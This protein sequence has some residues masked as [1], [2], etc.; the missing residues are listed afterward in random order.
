MFYVCEFTPKNPWLVKVFFNAPLHGNWSLS[1][2][3]PPPV[4]YWARHINHAL[5][6]LLPMSA[7]AHLISGGSSLS[8]RNSRFRCCSPSILQP[9]KFAFLFILFVPD[10]FVCFLAL[11]CFCLVSVFA[12]VSVLSRTN[13]MK[14]FQLLASILCHLFVVTSLDALYNRWQIN[15]LLK[16]YKA[17]KVKPAR[18]SRNG[19]VRVRTWCCMNSCSRFFVCCTSLLLS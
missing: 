16:Q 13:F 19:H 14:G 7:W 6:F 10:V 11:S 17:S 18:V 15:V 12:S 9:E 4:R 5:R 8:G 3:S 2:F 1:A